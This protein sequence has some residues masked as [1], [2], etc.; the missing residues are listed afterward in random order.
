MAETTPANS[1]AV[2][3]ELGRIGDKVHRLANELQKHDGRLI[4]LEE[5]H[6]ALKA[7]DDRHGEAIKSLDE[8]TDEHGLQLFSH[9]TAIEGIRKTIRTV[10]GIVAAI[11][12]A[13]GVFGPILSEWIKSILP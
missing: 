12:S 5:R 10:G 2:N 13:A 8:R 4:R 11:V 1:P 9:E 7:T 6:E 3:A